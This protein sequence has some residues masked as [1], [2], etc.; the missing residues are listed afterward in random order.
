MPISH[1]WP[2]SKRVSAPAA[3]TSFA[4][5]VHQTTSVP[6]QRAMP[7][8]VIDVMSCFS[9]S[10]AIDITV[11]RV[12]RE[13]IVVTAR[14]PD[15]DARGRSCA[16]R[17]TGVPNE[18]NGKARLKHE[19]REIDK[20]FLRYKITFSPQIILHSSIFAPS[21]VSESAENIFLTA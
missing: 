7:F 2:N 19:R 9:A 17:A 18:P 1:D 4:S 6:R 5:P 14:K 13:A 12:A 11:F 15:A 21:K 20:S 3:I 16:G 8:Y 10:T